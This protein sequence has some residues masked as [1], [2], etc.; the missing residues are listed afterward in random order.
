MQDILSIGTATVDAFLTI[1]EDSVHCHMNDKTYELSFPLGQKIPLENAEFLIGGDASN[2]SVGLSRLGLSSMLFAEIGD[3]EFA[4]KILRSLSE[5]HIDLSHVIQTETQSSFAMGLE[6]KGDRTLF[7]RHQKREH[8]FAFDVKAKWMYLSSLGEV[9]EKAYQNAYTSVLEHHMYLACNPGTL[10]IQAGF[11]QIATIL[12]RTDILFLNIDEAAELLDKKDQSVED[13]LIAYRAYG[14]KTVVLTDGKN[15]SYAKGPD[16]M[17]Y[18]VGIVNHPIVERTGAG[19]AYSSGF[20]AAIIHGRSTSEAMIWGTLN[21][22]SV[23]G[24]VGAQPG[25][26][27]THEMTAMLDEHKHTLIPKPV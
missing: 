2:V 8:Q 4:E 6:Y 23:V 25:L 21:A 10:Q 17:T 15:G 18:H 20:L 12:S 22:A 14:V 16:G 3:D 11:A 24:K 26:L 13:L 7:V 27:H 9:W 5:E 1:P 19:D